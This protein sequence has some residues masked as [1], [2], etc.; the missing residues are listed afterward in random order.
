MDARPPLI[1]DPHNFDLWI[2]AKF[3]AGIKIDTKDYIKADSREHVDPSKI[4]Q[5]HVK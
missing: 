2:Q 5:I 4:I 1:L 3:H